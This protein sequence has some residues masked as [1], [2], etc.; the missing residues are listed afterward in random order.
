MSKAIASKT[1]VSTNRV[2][3]AVTYDESDF[4]GDM[5]QASLFCTDEGP[6]STI[7]F[8]TISKTNVE[9]FGIVWSITLSIS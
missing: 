3:F 7:T 8:S 6:F 2:D 1:Y 5:V 9:K 4:A